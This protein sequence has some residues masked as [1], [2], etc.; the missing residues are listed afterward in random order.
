MSDRCVSVPQ[1]VDCSCNGF[2]N[3]LALSDKSLASRALKFLFLEIRVTFLSPASSDNDR[4]NS[5]VFLVNNCV[6]PY[7]HTKNPQ[8]MAI[9]GIAIRFI[10]FMSSS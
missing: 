1:R 4:A 3:H 8:T 6:S 2:G 10:F 9:I 5:L 7:H